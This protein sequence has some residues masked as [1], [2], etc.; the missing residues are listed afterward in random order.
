[1]FS[2]HILSDVERICTDVAFLHNGTIA[3][4]GSVADLKQTHMTEQ[5][6]VELTDESEAEILR[7][8]F[9]FVCAKE[10]NTVTISGGEDRMF[11][12]LAY[13]KEHQLSLRKLERSQSSLETLFLE[14]VEQ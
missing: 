8:E 14:V 2:T 5:F 13:I 12:V 1:M 7:T 9:S 3:L 11:D 4:C 6:T 10:G